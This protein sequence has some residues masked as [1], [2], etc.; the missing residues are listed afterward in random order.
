MNSLTFA[1]AVP[2][3]ARF[4]ILVSTL[5]MKDI[6]EVRMKRQWNVRRRF[7][8]TKDAQRRWDQA[9]QHLLEWTQPSKPESV[10]LPSFRPPAETE[11]KCEEC[12]LSAGID[13]S[14]DPG[15]NHRPAVGTS[16]KPFGFA[17]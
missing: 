16:A 9:Y 1:Y 5:A 15:P 7:Q 2:S 17:G 6:V 4:Q 3:L 12:D 14:S 8:L 11:V 13:Q 10:L